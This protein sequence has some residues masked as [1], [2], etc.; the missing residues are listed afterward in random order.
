[1]FVSRGRFSLTPTDSV[2]SRWSFSRKICKP[3]PDERHP[4]YGSTG[5]DIGKQSFSCAAPAT[6]NSLPAAVINCDT[7]SVFKSRLKTH[8]FNT[9][10]S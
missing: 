3:S 2:L 6:W 7:L 9:A 8:L 1:L 5:S 10:Y 4:F